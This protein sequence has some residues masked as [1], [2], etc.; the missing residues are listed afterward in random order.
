MPF[1]KPGT[2]KS[3]C[4]RIKGRKSPYIFCLFQ[5]FSYL[6]CYLFSEPNRNYEQK[7]KNDMKHW[8]S[9][10]AAACLL[11][12][13]GCSQQ[14]EKSVQPTAV[15][16]EKV[17][18]AD[19]LI[20]L[21]YP[22]K[23]KA[24]QDV[25]L[26]FKVS[27]TLQKILVNDGQQVRAGQLLAYLDPADYQAQLDATEAEYRQ[28]KADAERVMKLYQEEVTTASANDKAT[29]GLQ[30]ITAK[31]KHHQDELRYTRLYAPFDGYIQKRLYEEHETVGAGM[32]VLAMVGSGLPEVEIN[33]PAA[34]Y[35]RR[36]TFSTYSCTF[37]VYPGQ[38]YPLQALSITP[39]ANANQLYTMRLQLQRVPDLPLPSPGLNT[40]VNIGCKTDSTQTLL[41]VPSQA[42][43]HKDR[44]TC[45]FVF[46]P[47]DHTVRACEVAVIRL[48]SDGKAIVR[49]EGLKADDD[50][51]AAGVHHILDGET[52]RPLAAVRE[53]NVGGLL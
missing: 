18:S 44:R 29:Y 27:G 39:K 32:P 16:L 20:Q 41:S 10:G 5:T 22:G 38:V 19:H 24:A 23:V 36:S 26:S 51:V 6:C 21:E 8:L 25:S 14:A 9:C 28:V 1:R 30:Q 52:V 46:S 40:M 15:K 49:S 3:S 7:G 37:D 47:T 2:V 45:V 11:L 17:E 33:L 43:L 53:T 50:V 34:E 35:V 31:Y 12:L 48:T 42:L 4:K 13:V